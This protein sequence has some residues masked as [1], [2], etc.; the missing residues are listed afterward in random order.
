MSPRARVSALLVLGLLASGA[1]AWGQGH[2]LPP[3]PR[4]L[5]ERLA[6][7]D[8]VVVARVES[9]SAGRIAVEAESVLLGEPPASFEVK[10]SPSSPH[11]LEAGDR[12]LL[13]LRGARPPYVMVDEPRETIRLAD[14]TS[15]ERWRNAVSQVLAQRDSPEGLVALY[16]GWIDDGPSTLRDLALRALSDGDAAFQPLPEAVLEGRARAATDPARDTDARRKSALL[17]VRSP[18]ATAWLL[19]S[20]LRDGEADPGVALTALRGGMV[21]RSPGITAALRR[22]FLHGSSELRLGALRVAGSAPRDIAPEL[23]D[24]VE[25]LLLRE[26]DDR[27]RAEG[28]RIAAALRRR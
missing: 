6:L 4:P 24:E 1:P 17:A 2:P 20:A 10:R 8:V 5:H 27:V 22:A 18:A 26:A 15:T 16:V 13:A 7:A 12:A 11:P 28:E 23:A 19:E 14:E 21:H 3:Q 25:L 9:V